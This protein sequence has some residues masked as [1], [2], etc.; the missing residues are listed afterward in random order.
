MTLQPRRAVAVGAATVALASISAAAFT[1]TQLSAENTAV[2]AA[3]DPTVEPSPPAGPYP[4]SAPLGGEGE[5][6]LGDIATVRDS[7]HVAMPLDPYLTP[8][9]DIKLIDQARDI[10]SAACMRSLGFTGWTST[11]IRTWSPGDYRESDVFDYLDTKAAA[12][13]GYP[14]LP[15]ESVPRA[16]TESRH[17][18]TLEERKAFDGAADRTQSGRAIPAGGCAGQADDKLYGTMR[19]LPADPRGL[20]V[21]SRSRAMRDSRVRAA[22]TAWRACMQ[23]AGITSYD[24]PITAQNDPRWQSRAEGAPASAEEK[25]VAAAD[26]NCQAEVNLVGIYKAVRAAY[27]QRILDGNKGKIAEST[28]I[29]EGW[30]SR[31]KALIKAG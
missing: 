17:E 22:L 28:H 18:P 30:V 3:V 21:A 5:P 13:S 12:D 11:T 7:K 14:R 2:T 6:P 24:H 8:M 1:L 31:A 9:S 19:K 15:A 26:A 16:F 27:E 23:N 29:F 4:T 20:A 10:A 25:R